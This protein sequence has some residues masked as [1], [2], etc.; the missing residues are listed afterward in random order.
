MDKDREAQEPKKARK[1]KALKDRV[2]CSKEKEKGS[3]S[4]STEVSREENKCCYNENITDS[5]MLQEKN[6]R[7]K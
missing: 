6:L 1:R 2:D 4:N 3:R 7:R 5:Q